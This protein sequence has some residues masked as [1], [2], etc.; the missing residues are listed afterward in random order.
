MH[1]LTFYPLGNADCLCIELEN[2]RVMIVDYA[3]VKT[4]S[5]DDKRCDLATLL[6]TKL[7]ALGRTDVDVFC[8]THI[9]TD[10]LC[11]AH[12]FFHLQHAAKYQG[13]DRFKIRELWVPAGAITEVGCEDQSRIW[14]EEARYRLREG[15]DIRVFGR[16][17]SL[18]RWLED[19]KLSYEDRKHLITDAGNVIPGFDLATDQVEF[20]LHSPHAA[21][22]N[23]REVEDRNRDC[24]VMQAVFRAGA[25][26]TRVILPGDT[27][28]DV[29]CD[30]VTITEYHANEDRLDY[31]IFKVPHHCSYLALSDVKGDDQTEPEEEIRRWYDRGTRSALLVASSNVI[32]SSDTDQPPHFQAENY[33]LSVKD[34]KSGQWKVTMEHPN[35]LDP[36]PLVIEIGNLGWSQ[37]QASAAIGI[38]SATSVNPPKAG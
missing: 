13:G 33:Y 30:I 35:G 25:R 15:K 9:D 20:F 37:K 22:I 1:T 17:E 28:W 3:H 8:L 32:P 6:R 31:D 24:T 16:P 26:D 21:R 27:C 10:H 7:K 36:Q 29:M 23:K 2:G 12:E 5:A 19:N 34:A 18:K 4:D 38:A 14:R 11:Q